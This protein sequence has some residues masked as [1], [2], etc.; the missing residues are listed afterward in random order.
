MR[1]DVGQ[2]IHNKYRLVRLI[3]DGGMGSV[4]EAKH[5]VLGTK[6]ALKFLH[7]ELSR[8]SG[9]VQRFLQ[10]ARVSARIQSPHVV[11]VTDVDQTAEGLAFLVME[12]VEGKSLQTLYEDLYRDGRRLS[13]EEA[14]D[15]AIQMMEGLEAA[16]AEGVIHRDLKPDNVMITK[17]RKGATLV[18]LLDFGIAKLKVEDDLQQRKGLTRPGVVMGTPEYMAPEQA[19]SA[20]AVD[21]R[22]DIFS[23]GVIIFEML[24]GR[25]PVGGD[26]AH[27]IAAQYL[28]GQ[29]AQLNVL[30]PK[31]DAHLAEAVHKAMAAKKEDR[32]A[33]VAELR[34]AIEPFADAAKPEKPGKTPAGRAKATPAGPSPAPV[35]AVAAGAGV[36]AVGTPATNVPEASPGSQLPGRV[37][38]TLPPAD[39]AVP[40]PPATSDSG[41][42]GVVPGA[43]VHEGNGAGAM[44]NYDQTAEGLGHVSHPMAPPEAAP[45]ITGD[46]TE[47]QAPL[48]FEGRDSSPDTGAKAKPN[49]TNKGTE[50]LHAPERAGHSPVAASVGMLP[51][52]RTAAPLDAALGGEPPAPVVPRTSPRRPAPVAPRSGPRS[53]WRAPSADTRTSR[54]P[55]PRRGRRLGRWPRQSRSEPP[56]ASAGEG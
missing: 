19:F 3:G 13:Y 15:F 4:Y 25:R 20:D 17:D 9:L 23:L 22:A 51:A 55:R 31:I 43:G 10:E 41:V 12:F 29:V 5:E 33:S 32:F 35:A 28:T 6:V 24:A 49:K 47:E 52:T 54:L 30:N 45:A 7:P 53:R 44:P 50:V 36:G 42:V 48:A 46:A 26:E 34:E 40:P 11:R 14:L 56:R 2:L 18:K 16:H 37:P 39:A 21:A 1:P 27:Q 8:R 38:K